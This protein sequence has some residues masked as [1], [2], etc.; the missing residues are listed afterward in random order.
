MPYCGGR[1]MTRLTRLAALALLSGCAAVALAAP[2][3]PDAADEKVKDRAAFVPYRK[4]QSLPGKTVG[5]L[6]SDVAKVMSHDGRGGPADA[7]AFSRDSQSYRWMYVPAQD[8]AI[9]SGLNV[10]VGE[11]GDK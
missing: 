4:Y 6:V 9:I 7:M 1:L 10:H 3:P 8:K 2:A 11:K 5:I